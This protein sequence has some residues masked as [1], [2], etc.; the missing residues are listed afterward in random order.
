MVWNKQIHHVH[1][2]QNEAWPPAT[3]GVQAH[4][5]APSVSGASPQSSHVS[6]ISVTCHTFRTLLSTP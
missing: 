5:S 3:S 4:L 1:R 6:L 2:S